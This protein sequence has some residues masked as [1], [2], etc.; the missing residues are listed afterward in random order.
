MSAK[1]NRPVDPGVRDKDIEKKLRFYGIWE[2]FKLGKL[3]SN[4]QIDVALNSV[5]EFLSTS[6]PGISQLTPVPNCSLSRPSRFRNQ[7]ALY[8][9][10]ARACSRILEMLLNRPNCSYWS[11]TIIKFCKSSSGTLSNL[12]WLERYLG[13]LVSRS[14]PSLKKVRKKTR[15]MFYKVYVRWACWLSLMGKHVHTPLPEYGSF[16]PI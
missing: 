7:T 1:V 11:R 12:E 6:L 13:Q 9:R 5:S 10:R 8:R 14:Y 4:K 15:R 16:W 2:A 3:P